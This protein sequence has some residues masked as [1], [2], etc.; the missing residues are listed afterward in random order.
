MPTKQVV[1]EAIVQQCKAQV[2]LYEQTILQAQQAANSESKSSVGDKYET[3]RAMAQNDI[4]LFSSRLVAA[5]ENLETANNLLTAQNTN[6][7]VENGSFL[8]T[9]IGWIVIGISI[10]NV[11]LE[12]ETIFTASE[13]S[14]I[15]KAL[16]GK[17]E[18]ETILV[19]QK[20]IRILEIR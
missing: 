20:E 16:L 3:A 1:F 19:N 17:K 14:P 12:S 15:A 10:G 18:N 7:K 11:Q 4:A 8:K 13:S 9:T 5:K 2:E 6:E